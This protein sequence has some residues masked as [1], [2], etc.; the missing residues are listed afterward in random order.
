MTHIITGV[1]NFLIHSHAAHFLLTE[2]ALHAPL[3]LALAKQPS[4]PCSSSIPL[5]NILVFDPYS[6]PIHPAP[7]PA[8]HH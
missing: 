5:R 8:H 6:R 7:A 2:A 4:P 1:L 3:L